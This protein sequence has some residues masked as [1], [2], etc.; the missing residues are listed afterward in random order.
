MC[1]CTDSSVFVQAFQGFAKAL[2]GP[3]FSMT[4]PWPLT[5]PHALKQH[6]QAANFEDVKCAEYSHNFQFQLDDFVRFMV[7]PHGQFE[8]MLDKLQAAG[9]SNIHQQAPQVSF[10]LQSIESFLH[11]TLMSWF[12][13]HTNLT[14]PCCLPSFL[15]IVQRMSTLYRL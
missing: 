8:P 14:L 3:K 11:C 1:L 10:A 6:I 12:C 2:M 5:D 7:G 4:P 15:H 13:F 9:N